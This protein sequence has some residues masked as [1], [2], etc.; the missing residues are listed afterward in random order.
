MPP[1]RAVRKW[2]DG[3]LEQVE[4][5]ARID[6]A[7]AERELRDHE[8]HVATVL[9]CAEAVKKRVR[10][11]GPERD[12]DF[13]RQRSFYDALDQNVR[14]WETAYKDLC[15]DC[16]RHLAR[17]L[18]RAP[19][20][21]CGHNVPKRAWRVSF[22]YP[23]RDLCL[24]EKF[25]SM[26]QLAMRILLCSSAGCLYLRTPNIPIVQAAGCLYPSSLPGQKILFL[27]IRP[28]PSITCTYSSSHAH[29][30]KITG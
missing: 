9:A 21:K 20:S 5:Q 29:D 6:E 15:R 24:C 2:L 30:S 11:F 22:F 25:G 13:R 4:L 19:C 23:E 7:K 8:M 3:V 16:E 12:A 10:P 26:A 18:C 14:E 1:L 17:C 28:V 27:M